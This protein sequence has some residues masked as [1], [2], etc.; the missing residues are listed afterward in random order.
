MNRV[1]SMSAK[2]L[3]YYYYYLNFFLKT[4]TLQ[5]KKLILKG[6]FK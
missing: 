5:H 4:V 6:P 2:N 1:R 3:Y